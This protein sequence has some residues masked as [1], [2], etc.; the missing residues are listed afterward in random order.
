MTKRDFH[1]YTKDYLAT[2][3][4]ENNLQ[5]SGFYDHVMR[6]TIIT[7]RCKECM[8]VFTKTIRRL[9]QCPCSNCN[10][11]RF[12]K[13]HC[14]NTFLEYCEKQNIII[15]PEKYD[16]TDKIEIIGPCLNCQDECARIMSRIRAC[17]MHCK[18]C[19]NDI[20][21]EKFKETNLQ[22]FGTEFAMSCP[23]IQQ[24]QKETFLQNYG[25]DN[26]WKNK[27]IIEKIRQNLL[28]PLTQEK[29]KHTVS[30]RYGVEYI[31]QSPEIKERIKQANLE[32]FG[33]EYASQSPEIKE[34]IKQTNLER[35]GV[36][37]V[38]QNEVIA[39]KATET[40]RS[41]EYKEKIKQTNL[42]RYGVEYTSQFPKFKEKRTQTILE[43]YGVEHPFQSPEFKEK[44][45]Q[46][47]L[48]RYGTEYAI[49]NAQIAERSLLKSRKLKNYILPSGKNIKIQ[50]YE[51]YA[52]D[53]LLNDFCLDEDD[54][55]TCRTEVPEIWY[56]G[57]DGKNHRY[58]MDI[59]IKSL[60]KG[61]EVKSNWTI[62]KHVNHVQLKKQSAMQKLTSY[63][64][65]VMNNKG[66]IEEVL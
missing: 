29:I 1:I 10:R 46:T 35:Y 55:T 9:I 53:I 4:K 36:E 61:I 31:T 62:S 25:V 22:L 27:E 20:R 64:I 23:E 58:Y 14:M 51:S 57:E 60:D 2:F 40:F 17:G 65:W 5:L 19:I 37:Y 15:D 49:Q 50:G 11:I 45:K 16:V 6:D 33:V 44:A 52:L 59:Y 7:Y 13:T 66:A 39:K 8:S 41:S 26:P 3:C 54:I 63:E 47:N 28:N 12:K 56:T 32:R 34:K 24:R 30:E 21:L 43:R 18:K 42:Q 48:D 38:M